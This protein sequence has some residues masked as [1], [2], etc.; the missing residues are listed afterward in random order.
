MLKSITGEI[1]PGRFCRYLN[2]LSGEPLSTRSHRQ[3]V[4]EITLKCIMFSLER[5]IKNERIFPVAMRISTKS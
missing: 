2:R 3:H 5:V 4:E 1:G